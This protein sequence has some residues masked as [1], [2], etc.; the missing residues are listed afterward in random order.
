MERITA[1]PLAYPPSSPRTRPSD[2]RV[3]QFGSR[4]GDRWGIK[5]LTL[6]QALGRVFDQLSGF[7]KVGKPHRVDLDDVVVSTNLQT[8]MDG[9]PKSGQSAPAD[10]GAAVY[11]ILD[12]ERQCVPCDTYTRVEDNLAAI[13]STLECMRTIER[14]GSQMLQAAM[15]GFRALP[16]PENLER[17]WQDVLDYFGHNYDECKKAYQRK[18]SEYHPDRYQEAVT[19]AYYTEKFHELQKA[20]EQAQEELQNG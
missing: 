19:K 8:R 7:T 1:Y 12:G 13:A 10:P 4:N 9:L 11:F 18:C 16:A 5:Q 20:W 14:H 17:G 15:T 2:R 6:S 3:A